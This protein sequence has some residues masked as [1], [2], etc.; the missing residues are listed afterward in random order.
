MPFIFFTLSFDNLP[1]SMHYVAVGNN[2]SV[3]PSNT[4]VNNSDVPMITNR[5]RMTGEVTHTE[6]SDEPNGVKS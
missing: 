3:E 5:L 6:N 4:E 2:L 1:D